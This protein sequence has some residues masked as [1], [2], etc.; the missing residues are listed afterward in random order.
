MVSHNCLTKLDMMC[1]LSHSVIPEFSLDPADD[2]VTATEQLELMCTADGFPRPAIVWM[3][4][5]TVVQTD[6]R[7]MITDNLTELVIASSLVV[8]NTVSNDSGDYVCVATS[9][10]F[11]DVFSET[12]LVLIQ[13]EPLPLYQ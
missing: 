7:V 6:S 1:S 5:G 11:D 12:A 2:N 4:N 3:H 10:V 9:T 8:M 13:G